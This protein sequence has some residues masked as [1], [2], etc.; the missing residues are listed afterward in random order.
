MTKEEL[1]AMFD[2]ANAPLKS[3]VESL[4]TELAE[5]KGNEAK[6]AK[7]STKL[8]KAEEAK[9]A[10]KADFDAKLATAKSEAI[11]EAQ[12]INSDKFDSIEQKLT[13]MAFDGGQESKAAD[14]FADAWVGE[15]LKV[16]NSSQF[17]KFA[18]KVSKLKEQF[19]LADGQNITN[20]S[21]GGY[22]VP[23]AMANYILKDTINEIAPL[24]GLTRR[25]PMGENLS[26]NVRTGIP[27]AKRAGEGD[28]AIKGKS[29]Y[30]Q[31]EMNA[32]RCSVTVP[33]TWEYL[34]WTMGDARSQ[35][36]TD[37]AEGYAAKFLWELIN[38]NYA[39]KQ[40]EGILTNTTVTSAAVE[41]E[42]ASE[43]TF[44][45]LVNL[46]SSVTTN[47][48]SNLRYVMDRRTLGAVRKLQDGAGNYIFKPGEAGKPD[49]INGIP[50]IRTGVVTVHN[51][52]DIAARQVMPLIA[53][54]AYP[55]M[56]ADFTG[57]LFGDAKGMTVI[58]DDKTGAAEAT[59]FW[60][61][62]VWNTGRVALPEKFKLLKVKAAA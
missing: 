14:K 4:K 21:D 26:V 18:S 47:N 8:E 43:I 49:T 38:G 44:D 27:S 42:A 12:K 22:R 39:E 31:V 13:T 30:R 60:N 52:T 28:T 54:N 9:D 56:L 24:L 29:Q 15:F 41:T 36:Q 10:L 37:V 11:A 62:H 6:V 61:F 35:I 5:A 46:E 25:T 20:D 58:F 48:E 40:M 57:Y 2:E 16:K 45:D 34:N 23:E 55:I 3:E 53:D 1:Q 17:D 50:V 59:F 19:A 7:L 33:A 51:G 32:K